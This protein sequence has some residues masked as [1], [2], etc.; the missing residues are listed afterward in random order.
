MK[1]V[2]PQLLA[3]APDQVF[4]IIFNGH[5]GASRMN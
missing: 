5:Q 4:V 2:T 3:D 1:A